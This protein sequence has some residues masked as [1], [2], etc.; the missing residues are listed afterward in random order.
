MMTYLWVYRG[1]RDPEG[2]VL[3]LDTE[4]PDSNG[5]GMARYQDIV[6][7]RNDG[8]RTLASQRL[9]ADGTWQRFMTAVYRRKT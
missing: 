8:H 2:S 6:E 7:I 5:A 1:S 9:G 4:G 3:T